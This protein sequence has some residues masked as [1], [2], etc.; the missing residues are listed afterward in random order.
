M[1]EHRI[2]LRGG[3]LLRETAPQVA[4][5]RRITLP[6]PGFASDAG[7]I[8]LFRSFQRPPL[9]PARESLWLRL[10]DVPG[11]RSVAL[12]NRRIALVPPGVSS[13]LVPLGDDLLA[14]NELRL[15]V[16]PVA[17]RDTS[18]P[19]APWGEVALVI[20]QSENPDGST[21]F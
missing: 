5:P 3:W 11:L 19:D 18:E 17:S 13:L 14:R 4:T 16:D 21:A 8:V 2:R 1:S 12:N 9:D 20:V 7:G 10:D 15:D 6:L